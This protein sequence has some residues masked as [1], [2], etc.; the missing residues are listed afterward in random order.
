MM[1]SFRANGRVKQYQHDE[2]DNLLKHLLRCL[3]AFPV[4]C[5]SFSTAEKIIENGKTN[6]CSNYSKNRQENHLFK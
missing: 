5:A 4:T 1:V 6:N 3:N 2:E